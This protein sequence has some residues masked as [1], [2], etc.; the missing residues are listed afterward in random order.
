M[1]KTDILLPELYV[2]F[3]MVQQKNGCF[4]LHFGVNP[5]NNTLMCNKPTSLLL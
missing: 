5:I 3:D 4:N 1:A 2:W